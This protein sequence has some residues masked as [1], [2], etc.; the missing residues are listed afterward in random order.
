MSRKN[1]NSFNQNITEEI[2]M[3]K[4]ITIIA[5]CVAILMHT[6]SVEANSVGKVIS[7]LTLDNTK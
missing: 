2:T 5:V 7:H 1:K 6:I 4:V 3:K